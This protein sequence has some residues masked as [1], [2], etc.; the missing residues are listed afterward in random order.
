VNRCVG[1]AGAGSSP[2]FADAMMES[3]TFKP[4][5][6]PTLRDVAAQAGVT[7]ATVSRVLSG[8]SATEVSEATAIRVQQIADEIGYRPNAIARGLRTR[9]T[10]GIGL[11]VPD[12]SNPVYAAMFRGC[13]ER[14]RQLGYHVL[15]AEPGANDADAAEVVRLAREARVDGLIIG[16]ASLDVDLEHELHDADV[17]YVFMNRRVRGARRSVA[18]D[19][20]KGGGAAADYLFAMGHRTAGVLAGPPTI[21]NV[22]RRVNGF[23]RRCERLGL[24]VVW[25]GVVP[26]WGSMA[27]SRS[28]A[29]REFLRTHRPSAVFAASLV[30]GIGALAAARDIG[31]AIPA[32]LS[33]IVYDDAEV[34]AYMNPPLTAVRMPFH[35]MGREAVA[36][37]HELICGR[38]AGDVTVRGK[39]IIVERES[40][41]AFGVEDV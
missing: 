29:L 17:P 32:D 13:V 40:V 3:G 1:P 33:L 27:S 26:H 14:A 30:T 25:R 5:K 4:R 10:G 2:E 7:V 39:P 20:H 31:V 11:V 15:L 18:I 6:R 21:E 38:E 19:D 23:T 36:V 8:K 28:T 37:L 41:A 24:R 9:R 35:E 22:A 12:V 16:T 34:A